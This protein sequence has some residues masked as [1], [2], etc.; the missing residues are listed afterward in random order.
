MP[1]RFIS[2][3]AE[4]EFLTRYF[5]PPTMKLT[6]EQ[7]RDNVLAAAIVDKHFPYGFHDGGLGH[8]SVQVDHLFQGNRLFFA[9]RERSGRRRRRRSRRHLAAA[10]DATGV[11]TG[12][13]LVL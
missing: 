10:R 6:L 8:R 11:A 5:Q 13:R 3:E 1:S 9:D 7:R 2:K 4:I 12:L